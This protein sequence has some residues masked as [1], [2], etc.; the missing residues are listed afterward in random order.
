MHVANKQYED[1]NV[2]IY[3]GLKIVGI[4]QIRMCVQ[5][6]WMSGT[7]NSVAKKN[8]LK[9]IRNLY[10]W[11]WTVCWIL[12]R[13]SFVYVCSIFVHRIYAKNWYN[14]NFWK[15]ASWQNLVAG[16]IPNR[17]W[18][19]FTRKPSRQL[20]AVDVHSVVR[21]IGRKQCASKSIPQP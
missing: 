21:N 5:I 20:N 13:R 7:L 3:T 8:T 19:S 15:F 4:C 2:L 12:F 16:R 6:K 14:A 18:W 17:N 10:M 11:S 9:V 1:Y